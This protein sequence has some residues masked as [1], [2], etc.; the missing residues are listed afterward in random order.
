LHRPA[1]GIMQVMVASPPELERSASNDAVFAYLDPVG[2]TPPGRERNPYLD[3]GH[4]PDI[5]ERVWRDLGAELPETARCRVNGN[6]VLAH[7]TS[8]AVI[9]FPRGTS[10]ALWIPPGERA[11]CDLL[12]RHTWG[13]A[14]TTDLTEV[15]GEGWRWGRFDARE[16]GWCVAAHRWWDHDR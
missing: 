10:Y 15:V 14:T 8:G 7:H 4:H 13:N 2:P 12:T 16:P 6:P 9:A 11:D 1:R 3:T 5:V